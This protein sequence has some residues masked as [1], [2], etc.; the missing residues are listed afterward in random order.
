MKN[1][2]ETNMINPAPENVKETKA[3][4]PADYQGKKEVVKVDCIYPDLYTQA[5]YQ[6]EG[7]QNA[8]DKII[9]EVEGILNMLGAGEIVEILTNGLKT[10][11]TEE[12][13]LL[14]DYG[15]EMIETEHVK[16]TLSDLRDNAF[17]VSEIIKT[18]LTIDQCVDRISTIKA[19]IKLT[20][21]NVLR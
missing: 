19:K 21:K 15:D 14:D 5:Y 3:I 8:K 13:D 11:I 1:S 10:K 4:N 12:I 20:Q 2:G 6:A 7:I 9:T 18:I 16:N 17:Y